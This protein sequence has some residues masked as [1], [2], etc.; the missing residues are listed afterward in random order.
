MV[1]ESKLDS[2]GFL[3]IGKVVQATGLSAH[4]I[5]AWERRYG[6]VT[7]VRSAG[8]TRRYSR[9]DVSRLTLLGRAVSAGYAIGSI[10]GLGEQALFSL[11]S[12]ADDGTGDSFMMKESASY[13]E[14]IEAYLDH[15]AHLRLDVAR[16]ILNREAA[17]RSHYTLVLNILLPILREVG[18]RW[19]QGRF[20]VHHEHAVSVHVRS[21]LAVGVADFT[22]THANHSVIVATPSGQRHEFGAL[23]SCFFIREAGITPIYLGADIPASDIVTAAEISGAKMIVL[24]VLMQTD[25]AETERLFHELEHLSQTTPVLCGLSETHPLVS[26]VDSACSRI[27][28]LHSLEDLTTLPTTLWVG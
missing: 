20:G 13:G 4:T 23:T 1:S 27:R 8:G 3:A 24:S 12:A 28:L 22:E 7:P 11:I 21:L 9:T 5:R 10:V 16:R 25:H 14:V 17:R 19:E 2:A 6:A 18:E 26:Y 15:I